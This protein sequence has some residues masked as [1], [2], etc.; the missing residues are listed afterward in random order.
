[1][2]VS[3]KKDPRFW[4]KW[5]RAGAIGCT[6]GPREKCY[7]CR[8][9]VGALHKL[10]CDIERC[11]CC[12]GQ[13]V[14]CGC[15]EVEHPGWIEDEDEDGVFWRPPDN[16]RERWSGILYE[17]EQEVAIRDRMFVRFGGIGI[18]WIPCKHSHPEAKPSVEYGAA[19][20]EKSCPYQKTE[21]D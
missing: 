4:E 17:E 15:M 7:E 8:V 18:G 1:M 11:S 6:L 3:K 14:S 20:I 21:E 12:H 10:G 5:R 9:S 19:R 13:L 2:N 16:I